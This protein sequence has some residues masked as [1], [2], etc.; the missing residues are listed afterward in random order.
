MNPSLRS[1]IAIVVVM[2]IGALVAWAGSD[3]SL[4]YQGLSVFWW[5]GILAF[6]IQWLAFIPAYLKQTVYL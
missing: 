3:N 2:G 5:C 4:T 1:F 6:A